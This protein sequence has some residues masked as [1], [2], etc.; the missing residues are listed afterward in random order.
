MWACLLVNKLIN[1]TFWSR[2]C[3]SLVTHFPAPTHFAHL[4]RDGFLDINLTNDFPSIL[5][6]AIHS[7]FYW[8]IL[9]KSILFF[10]FKNPFKKIRETR[11]LKSIHE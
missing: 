5:S 4:S 3:P 2:R 9:K 10:G 7:P 6:H 1:K 11:K 8:R